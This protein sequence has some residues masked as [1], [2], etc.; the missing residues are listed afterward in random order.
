MPLRLRVIPSNGLEADD[1]RGPT[2][3]RTVEFADDVDEIRIGRR[4][5][6]DLSL[7]FA[8]LSGV[9]ARL[10]RKR[11]TTGELSTSW[12]LEDLESKNG[13]YVGKNRLRPGEQRLI[14]TGDEVDLAHVRL[15]FDGHSQSSSG[16]EGTG[17]IA[18]RLVSDLFHGS[19]GA[20]APTLSVISGAANVITLKLVDRDRP[21]FVGRSNECDMCIDMEE[22]SRKHASFMRS[23]NGVVVRD[24]ESK[25]GIQVNGNRV[26]VQRLSDG[27]VVEMGPLEIRLMDPEERYLREL[28]G[29][30]NPDRAPAG[31]SRPP[32]QVVMPAALAVS[33]PPAAAPL[34]AAAPEPLSGPPRHF[35][36]PSTPP[37]AAPKPG[38][39]S[40]F[41]PSPTAPTA[42]ALPVAGGQALPVAGVRTTLDENH[43][44][45]S[46][47]R[48]AA[49]AAFAPA[50]NDDH[51]QA[52]RPP[53]ATF[54]ALT[55]LAVIAAIV[56]VLA[57]GGD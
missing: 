50:A 49:D 45:I 24:L 26:T 54:V 35:S 15:V 22:L 33:L 43:P 56:A 12:F 32:V 52:R 19:P 41:S 29:N 25:N 7:P 3:E 46:P 40:R 5:D 11:T 30:P 36:A 2:T 27:D 28:D 51:S 38:A 4:A 21:Y 13:T 47:R 42:H 48:P 14:L 8:A 34:P 9:H 57:L 20:S 37:A 44:A 6:V 55:V 10:L 17:T 16:A 18:R 1:R 53:I 31:D 39:A 23:W